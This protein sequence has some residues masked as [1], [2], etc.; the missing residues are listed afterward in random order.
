M[1][2]SQ[3]VILQT[4]SSAPRRYPP[5]HL[6]KG[7]YSRTGLSCS[8]WGHWTFAQAGCSDCMV[9]LTQK[10]VAAKKMLENEKQLVSQGTCSKWRLI[11][12]F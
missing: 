1:A 3:Q 2:V 11:L 10:N 5:A 12:C 9:E 7:M 4:V 8:F 6:C